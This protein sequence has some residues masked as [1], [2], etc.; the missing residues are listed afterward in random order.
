MLKQRRKA[1]WGLICVS[2]LSALLICVLSIYGR[3]ATSKEKASSATSAAAQEV[4]PWTAVASDGTVD[5][6]AFVG[7]VPIFIFG[8]IL[9]PVG[10]YTPNTTGVAYNPAVSPN[11]R[12]ILRYNV[13]NTWET[14]PLGRNRPAWTTLELGST[15][16]PGSV[17]TA[18]LYQVDRCTGLR[19][20]ICTAINRDQPWPPPMLPPGICERCQPFPAGTIDFTN[21]LYYVEVIL[22]PGTGGPPPAAHTLR[23]L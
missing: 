5:E 10:L 11:T 16:P 7:G 18:T 9:P 4:V 21:N 22:S 12:L 19:R 14:G 8:P 6:S 2:T 15:A 1:L 3:T 20:E 13:T 17:V 23:I